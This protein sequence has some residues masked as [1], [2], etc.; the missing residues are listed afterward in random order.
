M[1]K[2]TSPVCCVG[3]AR[4]DGGHF[5]PNSTNE[6][7]DQNQELSTPDPDLITFQRMDNESEAMLESA[8]VECTERTQKEIDDEIK[9]KKE[10]QVINVCIL[11]N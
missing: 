7:C 2:S 6:K 10:K 1:I 9:R 4:S 8:L 11:Q 3:E 5:H